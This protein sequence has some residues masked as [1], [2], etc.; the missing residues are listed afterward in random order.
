MIYVN[1]WKLCVDMMIIKGVMW[2]TNDY[3]GCGMGML[4]VFHIWCG[5]GRIMN[6]G[7]R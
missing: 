3:K 4:F 7:S 6:Q 2:Y 5:M 1:K